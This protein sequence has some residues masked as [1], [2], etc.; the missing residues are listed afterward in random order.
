MSAPNLAARAPVSEPATTD[1][2][3]HQ[4]SRPLAGSSGDETP[5]WLANKKPPF[6]A[7]VG[8]PAGFHFRP[9]KTA[10]LVRLSDGYAE[11]TVAEY[12][13]WSLGLLPQPKESLLAAA[14][15]ANI[16]EP[17]QLLASFCTAGLFAHFTG[18]VGEDDAQLGSLRL[19][20]CC[21][22]LGNSE[23]NPDVYR[24]GATSGQPL[25][26]VDLYLY[27]LLLLS[28]SGASLLEL[29]RDLAA[30]GGAET[31]VLT[32]AVVRALPLVIG[33]GAAYLDRLA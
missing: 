10:A 14:A 30:E 7:A 13:F 9:E 33:M 15:A 28:T 23:L 5:D 24:I 25:L 19:Q 17:D 2:S 29:C 26:V 20:L 32:R 12:Q 18:V 11:L 1:G 16:P 21:I 6:L 4:A 27:S 8:I 31:S 3:G 22:G